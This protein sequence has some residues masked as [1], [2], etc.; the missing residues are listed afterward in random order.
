MCWGTI[1]KDRSVMAWSAALSTRQ[2]RGRQFCTD[3]CRRLAHV[4]AHRFGR[5]V[6]L[7]LQR[8][9]TSRQWN[10]SRLSYAGGR[11]GWPLLQGHQ[12]KQIRH[13]RHNN[14]RNRILLGKQPM[15]SNRNRLRWWNAAAR[16]C[17][18]GRLTHGLRC[19]CSRSATR[20]RP[21]DDGRV[22]LGLECVRR[23]RQRVSGARSTLTDKDRRAPM[24]ERRRPQRSQ[25]RPPMVLRVS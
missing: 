24:I 12:R 10:P 8:L 22:L 23:T 7:G 5:R 4:C 16:T 20:V 18:G 3:L 2:L 14:R 11:F 25:A 1:H 9:R 6:L 17:R 19:D 15:G 21:R 13:V